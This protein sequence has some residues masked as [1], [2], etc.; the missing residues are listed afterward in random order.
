MCALCE[1]HH[2]VD[3]FNGSNSLSLSLSPASLSYRAIYI[4]FTCVDKYGDARIEPNKAHTKQPLAER[5]H[6]STLLKKATGRN[7]ARQ[8]GRFSLEI[9]LRSPHRDSKSGGARV[10]PFLCARPFG[11][12]VCEPVLADSRASG[13]RNSH[14]ECTVDGDF[15]QKR[16]LVAQ[17][18]V[19]HFYATPNPIKCPYF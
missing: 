16:Y 9:S 13:M 12:R 1:S 10:W 19:R 7:I 17:F 11:G 5:L 4:Y 6:E 3:S 15:D 2:F 14:S 18:K 8:S